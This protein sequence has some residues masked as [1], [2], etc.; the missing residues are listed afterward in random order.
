MQLPNLMNKISL[1]IAAMLMTANLNAHDGVLLNQ[2][3]TNFTSVAKASIPSVVSIRVRENKKNSSSWGSRDDYDDDQESDFGSDFW[4]KFFGFGD[5]SPVEPREGQ[6]SGFIVSADGYIITNGHVVKDTSEIVVHLH[7]GSEFLAK[8]IGVDGNTDIA[9][10]KIEATNLPFLKLGNSDAIEVGEWV[11]AIGTPIGLEAS[12]TSGI[13]SAKGRNN[14]SLARVEDFIQT[15]AALY[16]GNSGGPLINMAAD[17]IGINTAIASKTGGYIGMGFAIP[18]NIA[19]N[20]MD[21]LI[22]KG[23]V[24]RGFIGVLLQ[25]VSPELAESFGL[26]KV[27]GALIALVSPGS[28]AEKA[29]IRQGDIILFY[30]KMP[31]TNVAALRTVI[32]MLAP[33]ST[34]Q[35]SI[36]RDRQQ[37]EITVQVGELAEPVKAVSTAVHT[38]P[39]V[40]GLGLSVSN[41]SP[42]LAL[43]LGLH[44]ERGVIV[45][46]VDAGSNAKMA[47]MSKGALIVSVNQQKVDSVE[48]FQKA[49][50][51]ADP[52]RPFLFLVK[53][54]EVVK[55]ISFKAK[56]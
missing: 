27:E 26:G 31:V 49:I 47:G 18:S 39:I 17:V 15:D 12:V 55:F 2:P 44:G 29:G 14:L 24:S 21:Q 22:S 43:K 51:A 50:Q 6:G 3:S 40:E 8:V 9:L 42:E 37:R 36:I 7:N 33:G 54:G 11:L 35:F 53:V 48:S 16:L 23:S 52:D 5:S 25:D 10:I 34:L 56:K 41:I 32:A 4:K 30:N 38:D 19:K 46:K 20:V 1:L 28:P 13:V 45:T